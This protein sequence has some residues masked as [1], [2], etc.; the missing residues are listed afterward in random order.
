MVREIAEKNNRHYTM[1]LVD[2]TNFSL[3]AVSDFHA[4]PFCNAGFTDVQVYKKGQGLF[5]TARK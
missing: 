4:P 5:L 2:Y 1:T 3:S